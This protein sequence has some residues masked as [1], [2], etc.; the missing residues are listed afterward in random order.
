M[1][2]EYDLWSRLLNCGI[3][4]SA[5]TGSDWFICSSNRVYVDVGTDFSYDRWLDRLRSGPSF[6]TNGPVLR[7]TVA[8][9]PPSNDVLELRTAG[10]S[11]PGNCG[12][13]RGAAHRPGRDH[14]RWRSR[15]CD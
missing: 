10:P 5:S 12:L 11:V 4:L 3:R 8:E 9:C 13:G 6:I 2:P 1:T 15:R 7:L 14:P